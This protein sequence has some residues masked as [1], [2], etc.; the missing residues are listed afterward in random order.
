MSTAMRWSTALEQRP[1]GVALDVLVP[2]RT[3]VIEPRPDDIPGEVVIVPQPT[4]IAAAVRE[5]R[6]IRSRYDW[7][8]WFADLEVAIRTHQPRV[9]E[10]LLAE[11]E[12]NGFA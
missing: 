1:T 6:N 10:Q 11:G 12:L 4:S 5:L 9:F 7:W 8:Q 2:A 3:G